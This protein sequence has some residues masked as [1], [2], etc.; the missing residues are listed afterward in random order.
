MKNKHIIIL[1]SITV[2]ICI[3]AFIFGPVRSYRAERPENYGKLFPELVPLNVKEIIIK[4]AVE[5]EAAKELFGK[6]N[7]NQSE[8]MTDRVLSLS[9]AAETGWIIDSVN[10]PADEEKINRLLQTVAA[11]DR[12]E[13]ITSDSSTH[14]TYRVDRK[15][16]TSL[17]L[18]NDKGQIVADLLIG[19]RTE[20][21][22]FVRNG[23]DDN[24]Y[25][26]Q[27]LPKLAGFEDK[28]QALTLDMLDLSPIYEEWLDKSLLKWREA[29]IKWVEVVLPSETMRFINHSEWDA[30]NKR[31]VAKW[32]MEGMPEGHKIKQ[33][34]VSNL[35]RNFE[36][37]NIEGVAGVEKYINETNEFM[38]LLNKNVFKYSKP[39]Y[40][41]SEQVRDSG[42]PAAANFET[43]LGIKCTIFFK[44]LPAQKTDEKPEE[45]D[46]L[47][48]IQSDIDNVL[49][50][51]KNTIDIGM[52]R[53]SLKLAH[54]L[55]MKDRTR[56]NFDK[57]SA[58][59]HE[60]IPPD[61]TP[62][63]EEPKEPAT[64]EKK[65]KAEEKKEE[66]A[67]EKKEET[68]GGN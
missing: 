37:M 42:F 47:A 35:V 13:V 31:N 54:V 62:K 45:T 51:Q 3:I 36:Y 19:K 25:L 48:F 65:E 61:K 29:D 14:A 1:A 60:P 39:G 7:K 6:L 18:K 44:V 68:K 64:P 20:R 34:A 9:R 49:K 24:V 66:K 2:V 23:D 22:F 30:T 57:P 50:A 26:I 5:D 46:C 12:D 58:E 11:V 59:Y 8:K 32:E 21:G 33:W 38:F 4:R 10:Y 41:S 40:I 67:E 28:R 52:R 56:K 27:S 17:V 15:R 16:G 53:L 55:I 63:K 43:S